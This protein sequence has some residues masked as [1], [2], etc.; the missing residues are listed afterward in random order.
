MLSGIHGGR[1]QLGEDGGVSR[2]SGLDST[3]SLTKTR[4]TGILDTVARLLGVDG[5]AGAAACS[6]MSFG[7]RRNRTGERRRVNQRRGKR[8]TTARASPGRGK[9]T[10]ESRRWPGRRRHA[11]YGGSSL[12]GARKKTSLPLGWAASVSWAENH[13]KALFS[14]SFYFISIICCALLNKIARHFI[15]F[16]KFLYGLTIYIDSH[17][18][19]FDIFKIQIIRTLNQIGV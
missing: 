16:S 5:Y 19:S 3:G 9:R 13:G 4:A 14:F 12:A 1:R 6:G 11:R 8:N 18:K 17:L 2:A 7:R 15:K 10:R